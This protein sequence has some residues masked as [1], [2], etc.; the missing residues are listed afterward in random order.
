M[1]FRDLAPLWEGNGRWLEMETETLSAI[2]DLAWNPQQ[3]GAG[4]GLWSA[5]L[6]FHSSVLTPRKWEYLRERFKEWP[7]SWGRPRSACGRELQ[8][9]EVCQGWT[10]QVLNAATWRQGD[11]LSYEI[12]L[13]DLGLGGGCWGHPCVHW[14]LTGCRG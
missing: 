7:E 8:A 1:T 3:W 5:P 11:D 13:G 4:S 6:L 9:G 12:G 2:G 10:G 14:G